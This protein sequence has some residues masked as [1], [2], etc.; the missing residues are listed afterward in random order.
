MAACGFEHRQM[1]IPGSTGA[2]AARRYRMKLLGDTPELS[3]GLDAHLADLDAA[4]TFNCALASCCSVGRKKWN[5]G[6]V[7]SL[8]GCL[9]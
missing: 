8:W 7:S 4:V 9:G 5:M 2:W 6:K 3:R 1:R